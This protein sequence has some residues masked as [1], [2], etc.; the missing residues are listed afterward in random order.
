MSYGEESGGVEQYHGQIFRRSAC[1][2][3]SCFKNQAASSGVWLEA[4][5]FSKSGCNNAQTMF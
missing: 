2:M 3:Q 5:F 4:D 1:K